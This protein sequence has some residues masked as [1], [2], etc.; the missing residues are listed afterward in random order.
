MCWWSLTFQ[1][2]GCHRKS[3]TWQQEKSPLRGLKLSGRHKLGPINFQTK[4]I[5]G[6][7]PPWLVCSTT[8]SSLA[9]SPT[10]RRAFSHLTK[11]IF[12][13]FFYIS[14]LYLAYIFAV[15]FF[16][17]FSWCPVMT[18]EDANSILSWWCLWGQ[19]LVLALN[20]RDICLS[21]THG[22]RATLASRIPCYTLQCYTEWWSW[23]Q[24]IT[25][26]MILMI[27]NH[28]HLHGERLALALLSKEEPVMI[29]LHAKH[30]NTH[31]I[32]FTL[33]NVRHNMKRFWLIDC[34]PTCSVGVKLLEPPSLSPSLTEEPSI[35]DHVIQSTFSDKLDLSFFII[36]SMPRSDEKKPLPRMKRWQNH[37]H[38]VKL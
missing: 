38:P 24:L 33:R 35:C 19:S 23:R 17:M 31:K 6:I 25:A 15:L 13:H 26:M 30:V 5:L 9:R 29:T 14:W 3:H 22:L 7:F 27:F 36:A 37:L 20:A 12:P 32:L 8:P 16:A 2:Q 4:T 1:W 18:Y 10:P 21:Y 11:D 28:Y 34:F